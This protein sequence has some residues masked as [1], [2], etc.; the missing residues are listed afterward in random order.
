MF[1]DAE[2]KQFIASNLTFGKRHI[3]GLGILSKKTR[4]VV[5]RVRFRIS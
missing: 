1:H 5:F 3:L 4:Q 2:L